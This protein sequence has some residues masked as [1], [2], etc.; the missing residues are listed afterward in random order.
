MNSTVGL[1]RYS[2]NL[3]DGGSY[4]ASK[5]QRWLWRNWI[6]FWDSVPKGE[7]WTVLNGDL[8]DVNGKHKSSQVISLNETDVMKMTVDVLEPVLD[9]S[10]RVFVVR[11]TA[12]HTG[13][14]GNIEEKIALDIGAEK[15]GDN[16]SWWELLLDC[17]GVKFYITHHGPLGRLRHTHGNALNRR[18]VEIEDLFAGRGV[19]QVTIQSHNHHFSTS[20]DEYKTKV[21]AL[22]SWQLKTDFAKRIGIIEQDIV[23]GVW[24]NC[25]GGEYRDNVKRYEMP[26]Q[27]A[28]KP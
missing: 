24:F 13:L 4:Q 25:D 15:C 8:V 16:Y 23:G 10:D 1:C 2:V 27:G 3:D 12:A 20:S 7:V 18:A 17:D 21:Y 19:P 11:G 9:K 26:S 6:D 22:P 5:G 14:S 28:W